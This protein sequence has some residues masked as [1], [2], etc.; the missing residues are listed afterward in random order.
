MT[1]SK[2]NFIHNVNVYYLDDAFYVI[3][4]VRKPPI[5]LRT[6]V[7]PL[8]TSPGRHLEKLARAIESAR[9]NSNFQNPQN[10]ENLERQNWD[11]EKGKVW[12]HAEKLWNIFWEED[13]SVSISL[14]KPAGKHKE[15]I[16][17]KSVPDS[18]R[19]LPAPVSSPDIAQ[20]ILNQL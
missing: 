2:K 8:F 5:G 14:S 11:G 9:L 12:E 10:Q 19:T 7:L 17:W 18:E 6:E 3:G 16:E 15:A 1:F 13:G 20:E 4:L